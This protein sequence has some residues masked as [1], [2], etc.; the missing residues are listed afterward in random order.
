VVGLTVDMTDTSGIH[1]DLPLDAQN[2][3]IALVQYGRARTASR[4]ADLLLVKGS[5]TGRWAC[6]RT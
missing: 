5:T 3:T 6:R 1:Y 4:L 2:G